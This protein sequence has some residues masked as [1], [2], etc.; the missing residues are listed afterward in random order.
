MPTPLIDEG[1]AR[2][3]CG[4]PATG[5]PDAE[6]TR[7][8][9][10]ATAYVERYHGQRDEWPDDYRLGALRLATGLYRDAAQ[11]GLTEPF[12]TSNTARRATDIEIEQL[13]RIG[14]F[15]LPQIG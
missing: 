2:V 4:L 11:K 3:A 10:A 1:A 9:A 8:I 14:R 13:L 12:G 6:L 15:A 5:E 7:A